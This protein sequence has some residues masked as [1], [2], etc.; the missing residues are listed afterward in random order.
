MELLSTTSNAKLIGD[1]VD[2]T[3]VA[4]FVHDR[5][6][7]DGNKDKGTKTATFEP[8]QLPPG[9]YLVRMSYTAAENRASNA[10]VVVFSADGETAVRVNEREEPEDGIWITLGK[11]RFEK[12]GQAFVIV[13]NAE[14]DG[15]V[16]VDAVHFSPVGF[17]IDKVVSEEPKVDGA[18]LKRLEQE[19]AKLQRELAKRPSFM[20]VREK[21]PAKDIPILI[22]GNVHSAG[23]VVPRGFLAAV[24]AG[25]ASQAVFDDQSSGRLQ[26]ARWLSDAR[27]PLTARVYANRVWSWLIGQGLVA[28]TSNFGTD[29]NAAFAPGVARLVS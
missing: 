28:T 24:D 13:S 23:E 11:F 25:S 2:G 9:E 14:A 7:H 29:R 20:T 6:L 21:T 3:T 18:E 26:L 17:E 19:V 27:N 15:H 5:Y 8:K 16:V 10:K 4:G 1:W 12:D 22:R